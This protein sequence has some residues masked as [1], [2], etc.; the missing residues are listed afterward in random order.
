MS[1]GLHGE[2]TNP[3]FVAGIPST[4]LGILASGAAPLAQDLSALS[5]PLWTQ[6]GAGYSYSSASAHIAS[7]V[8]RKITGMEL[9][10][11]ID[12]RLAKPIGWGP[13]AW[14]LRRG[15]IT[16]RH[17][18]GGGDIALRSTDHLRFLYSILHKGRW[19]NEQIIPAEYI[20]LCSKPSKWNTHAPLSLMFE[21]NA[22]NHLAGAPR[23]AF[24]KSGGGGFGV[25]VIPS[26]DMVIYKMAGDDS[27]YNPARTGLKQDYVYD[28]SRD[29]W[30]P[31]PRS[32]FHDGPIGTDDGVR[33][34]IE[35]VVAAAIN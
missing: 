6:P 20:E 10:T 30:K 4:K 16:L 27:Q 19:G 11:Y 5:T 24:F 35:M 2:G 13:W 17:T 21:N 18:P 23:D 8:L 12:L 25:I 33:R 28:G 29:H 34:V 15:D 9:H 32:Q 31:A 1:A 22:D 3:G 26:L 7:M 14:A